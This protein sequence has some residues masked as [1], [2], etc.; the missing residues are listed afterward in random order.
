MNDCE[1][2]QPCSIPGPI[3]FRASQ[4]WHAGVKVDCETDW[5]HPR[6][7]IYVDQT[8][9]RRKVVEQPHITYADAAQRAVRDYRE[10]R[11]EFA[12]LA[13]VLL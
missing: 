1:E 2:S 11:G 6:R 12:G 13:P 4:C 5:S 7:R 8:R 10:E 9:I 3:A